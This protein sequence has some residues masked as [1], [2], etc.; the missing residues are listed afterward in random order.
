MNEHLLEGRGAFAASLHLLLTVFGIF[1]VVDLQVFASPR[2]T[3]KPL[4]PTF[5]CF[6]KILISLMEK[7]RGNGQR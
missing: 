2:I 1:Q 6:A 7:V 4:V 3:L 5:P